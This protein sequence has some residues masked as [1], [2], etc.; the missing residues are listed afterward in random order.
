MSSKT[1]AATP[2]V[3]IT[4]PA[5]LPLATIAGQ[6]RLLHAGPHS[7]RIGAWY[8]SAQ[9]L[10]ACLQWTRYARKLAGGSKSG[11]GEGE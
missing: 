9:E 5:D 3:K 7:G 6:A 8:Y 11:G 4:W 10:D 1:A 2:L